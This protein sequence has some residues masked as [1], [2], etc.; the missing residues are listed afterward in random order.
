MFVICK[1]FVFGGDLGAIEE[2]GEGAFVKDAVDNHF[3]VGD[4]EVEAPV[5]G[6]KAVEGLA[7]AIHLPK[8]IAIKI[9][10]VLRGDLKLVENR[11]LGQGVELRNL[12]R[13]DF[14][15]DDLKH[16]GEWHGGGG[17]VNVVGGIELRS[18][19]EGN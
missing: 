6:T 3:V 12:G 4:L 15:E 9:V 19:G 10:E 16:S 13:G 1:G 8:F 2:V 14:V 5:V 7:I 11:E 17:L 18:F